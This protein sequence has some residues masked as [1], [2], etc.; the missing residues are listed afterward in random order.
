M[1]DS[2]VG[3]SAEERARVFGGYFRANNPALG[4]TE[5]TGM[6]LV[7]TRALVERHGG[8]LTIESAPGRG[9]TV[10]LTRP[11]ADR[12]ATATGAPTGQRV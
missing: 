2:G 8:T 7:I 4:P 3:M 6:G 10:A 11:L 1:A 12:V 9:T 5:G